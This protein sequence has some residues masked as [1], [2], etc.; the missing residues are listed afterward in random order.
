[1]LL[2]PVKI[3]L[4][5]S[6]VFLSLQGW[7]FA[8][9][10]EFKW[11]LK[12]SGVDQGRSYG[13]FEHKETRDRVWV[14][15]G[16]TL[17]GR[18]VTRVEKFR[19]VIQTEHGEKVLTLGANGNDGSPFGE[20]TPD[21]FGIGTAMDDF[22]NEEIMRQA[23]NP[24]PI[25]EEDRQNIIKS[26]EEGLKEGK[27][28]AVS[29]SIYF[30]GGEEWVTGL[31]TQADFPVLGLNQEDLIVFINGMSPSVEE[32]KWKNI[33]DVLKKANLLIF[34]FVRDGEAF[35]KVFKVI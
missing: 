11:F 29:T 24:I 10:E 17:D 12:G 26:L 4:V 8:A 28:S 7:T 32:K 22:L 30:M 19:V 5:V 15:V 6:V 35:S 21:D 14:G 31:R 33:L 23:E 13:I 20:S 1:M 16:E 3:L 2:Q 25:S 27:F 9:Q 18:K 34:A